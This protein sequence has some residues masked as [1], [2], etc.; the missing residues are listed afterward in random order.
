LRLAAGPQQLADHL[1]IQGCAATSH[2]GQCVDEL[3]HVGHPVLEQVAHAGCAA[4]Q[5]PR[6]VPGLDVLGEHEYPGIGVIAAEI[7]GGAQTFVGVRRWHPDVDNGDVRA[8][9][10]HR[11]QQRARVGDRRGH[12]VTAVG[13]QADESFPHHGRVFGDDHAHVRPAA[14][15]G[16]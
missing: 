14:E 5:Q 6:G 13:E 4:L 12:L 2:T 7:E 15:G 8:V 1:G 16:R 11:G 9:S 10:R 3:R